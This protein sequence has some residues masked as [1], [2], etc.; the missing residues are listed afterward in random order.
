MNARET[1]D[2]GEGR[3]P[4][5]VARL[6]WCLWAAL[7]VGLP[8]VLSLP[9]VLDAEGEAL[10]FS[11]TRA[12]VALGLLVGAAYGEWLAERGRRIVV[13]VG[14]AASAAYVALAAG[15]I[16]G[17]L[18]VTMDEA[19]ALG[20]TASALAFLGA[21]S[22]ALTLSSLLPARAPEPRMVELASF[23]LLAAG[24]VLVTV[25]LE[26]CW[27]VAR[28]AF[29]P[30]SSESWC[31]EL[32]Y[33]LAGITGPG[34]HALRFGLARVDSGQLLVLA[35]WFALVALVTRAFASRA[36]LA[37]I[38]LGILLARSLD[39]LIL[40][41]LDELRMLGVALLI[42]GLVTLALGRRVDGRKCAPAMLA[43]DGL[44]TLEALSP[45][46]REAVEGRLA[47]LSSSKVAASMG[48]SPSTV[49]NL[50]A[51]ATAKLG[52]ASL[53]ELLPKERREVADES[54][55][56]AA[57]MHRFLSAALALILCG[58]P[59][60]AGLAGNWQLAL[61]VGELIVAGALA[62]LFGLC[63]KAVI[64]RPGLVL[65]GAQLGLLYALQLSLDS[66][67][68][69]INP[70]LVHLLAVADMAILSFALWQR[71]D[72]LA[73]AGAALAALP[74]LLVGPWS[75]LIAY[76]TGALLALL[77]RKSV[78]GLPFAAL[79]FG[80][81]VVVG[82]FSSWPFYVSA[83]LLVL[84][85]E[86]LGLMSLSAV[87][88]LAL[89]ALLLAGT[90]SAHVIAR[91]VL[92]ERRVQGARSETPSFDKRTLALCGSRGLGETQSA[93]ALC[94]V[95]GMSRAEICVE[96]S[97][98]PGTV[99]AARATAYRAFG[100]HSSAAL[101]ELVACAVA[102]EKGPSGS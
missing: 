63:P 61:A 93:I 36:A 21:L 10:A 67:L 98:A 28:L 97:V 44:A 78:L 17:L 16:L 12:L 15:A 40:V 26:P 73:L 46:E 96:L 5:P 43:T 35:G 34:S 6:A 2:G 80:L 69:S 101:A 33:D 83:G 8:P 57:D 37:G 49:R 68:G 3:R 45:R 102:N 30:G 74:V 23:A 41:D 47:G 55:K 75:A 84:R 89:G 54:K 72:L 92:A 42:A 79:A 22:C 87:A 27:S 14:F 95:R 9:G 53:D 99:N 51:R 13:F 59:S 71:E 85:S 66:G 32:L 7:L 11:G 64:P 100:V 50:Q 48:V 82:A 90:V 24:V 38:G 52:V 60:L 39:E 29:E 77:P 58:L 18:D 20:F 25:G 62:W 65:V 94:I 4:N 19:V 81:G 31:S 91:G 70:T 1:R 88:G 86:V 76:S 56:H